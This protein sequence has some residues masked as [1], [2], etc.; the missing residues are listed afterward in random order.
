LFSMSERKEG[1]VAPPM[2]F[3]GGPP[4]QGGG[5]RNPIAQQKQP[6][7]QTEKAEVVRRR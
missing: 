5:G 4:Q 6:A 7:Q 1:A 3:M 2:P